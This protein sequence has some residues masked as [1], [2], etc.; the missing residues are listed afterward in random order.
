M[1]ISKES[2]MVK[3]FGTT[4]EGWSHFAAGGGPKRARWVLVFLI[5]L[6]YDVVEYITDITLKQGDPA[7][8][9]WDIL[10]PPILVNM[11]NCPVTCRWINRLSQHDLTWEWVFSPSMVPK[12]SHISIPSICSIGNSFQFRLPQTYTPANDQMDT[13]NGWFEDRKPMIVF[14]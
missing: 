11:V 9:V 1:L 14:S 5:G 12:A 6:G 4:R 7:I 2:A 3:V 8:F 13:T 10:V